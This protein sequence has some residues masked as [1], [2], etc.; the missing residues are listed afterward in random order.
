VSPVQPTVSV[1][2]VNYKGADDTIACLEGFRGLD[3]PQES[4]EIVVVDN[5][6]GGDDVA[7]IRAAAPGVTVI[8]SKRN[9]GF[10]GG[11]NLGARK[12]SGTHLAFVNNDAR[13]DPQFLRAAVGALE[14]QPLIGAVAAKVLDWEGERVDFV[15]SGL[16]WYGQGFKLHVGAEDDGSFDDERDVLFGT[17]SAL[18]VRRSA[19]DIIDGFDERYFMFFE[20]VDLGWRLWLAGYS[21]RYVPSALVFHRHHASMSKLGT[22]REQF[23]LERNALFTIY[24]NYDDENLALLL[25]PALALAVRRGVVLGGADADALNL[26]TTPPVPDEPASAEVSKTVLASTYAV[27]AFVRSLGSLEKSRREIQRTRVRS[28]AEIVRMFGRPL[29]PNIDAPEF[30][31]DFRTVSEVFGVEGPFQGRRRVLVLTGDTLAPRMAGPAIRALQISKALAKEHEVV[32]ATTSSCDLPRSDM[33]TLHI[34]S[35]QH[36]AELER[37]ADV[38]VFQG[39][40]MHEYPVLNQSRKPIVVDMYD[41]FHLEQLEQ[42]RDLGEER[43]RD[44]VQSATAVLNEQILRG[45]FFLCASEKQR[46]F[47]LGQM[48]GLGRVN[49]AVYDRDETLGS[50][51]SVVPFGVED[52]P[53]V[54]TKRAVKGVIPGIGE[55]DK[56]VL[57][58]GGIYNWFDPLT[59]IRAMALVKDKVPNARLLFM[60]VKHPNPAVPEM[61]MA[62]QA[63]DLAQELGLLDSTVVFNYEW[64]PYDQRHNFLLESDIGVSTHLDHIETAFSFRTRILD[65]MWTSL[66][67]VCTQGDSLATLVEQRELGRT[68]PAG[69]VEALAAELIALLTD[70]DLI[71]T[72]RA[73]LAGIVPEYRWSQVLK[74]LVAY[75]R[76]PK[77]ADDLLDPRGALRTGHSLEIVPPE[78]GGVRG[79]LAL[80]GTYLREGG[81]RMLAGKVKARA[82]RIARGRLRTRR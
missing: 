51:I 37:W 50:L 76:D 3:W 20:D 8:A 5:A 39:Y 24:K 55:D 79:D 46:D 67:I 56:V 11:C 71:A 28:D 59:L 69:D 36:M 34:N 82:V 21:V 54:A 44:V 58:G 65:Y 1:V 72:C 57:W 32:L 4:L 33:R 61:R 16:S 25:G 23:L 9:L 31:R 66:P 14:A 19:F 52:E 18:V 68:V 15:A 74:P 12:S 47:W 29:Q 13:P 77:R 26:E 6:S 27:D 38:I 45:D 48:A 30:V 10:A 78:W 2:I 22:W 17:G 40:L 41:P 35:Q 53:A 7:R 64:V 73:N 62:T 75:C 42:A 80:V 49:P 70:E 43:R 81:A 63:R 60:G